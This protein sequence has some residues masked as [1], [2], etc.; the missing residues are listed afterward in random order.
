MSISEDIKA[1][2]FAL[3]MLPKRYPLLS[4]WEIAASPGRIRRLL[5]ALN[6]ARKAAWG[7]AILREEQHS[8]RLSKAI[9][10]LEISRGALAD[11]PFRHSKFV[12]D[13]AAFLSQ[14]SQT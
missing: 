9:D 4:D 6:E 7:G 14:D 8:A 1:L 11:T 2:E 10:L 3:E 12:H 5:D 13:I